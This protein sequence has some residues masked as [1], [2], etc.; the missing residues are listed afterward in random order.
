[1][2]L[3]FHIFSVASPVLFAA[4]G[5][6]DMKSSRRARSQRKVE[7]AVTDVRIVKMRVVE[8]DLGVA[9]HPPGAE[10]VKRTIP[11]IWIACAIWDIEAGKEN[12]FGKK[13]RLQIPAC[14]LPGHKTTGS[15]QYVRSA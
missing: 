7:K 1:M 11:E 14:C 13:D 15:H 6:A 10:E 12:E 3:R 8:E 9:V 2:S 4:V 5:V